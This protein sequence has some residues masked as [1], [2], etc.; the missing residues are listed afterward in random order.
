M[1]II[2][3][4]VT[5]KEFCPLALGDLAIKNPLPTLTSFQS[6]YCS[7]LHTSF[8]T[9]RCVG[10]PIYLQV[11]ACLY[12]VKIAHS[13]SIKSSICQLAFSVVSTSLSLPAKLAGLLAVS[14][15]VSYGSQSVPVIF[16]QFKLATHST[17]LPVNGGGRI[18][19]RKRQSIVF[20][21]SRFSYINFIY[22]VIP[23]QVSEYFHIFNKSNTFSPVLSPRFLISVF[24]LKDD[25][26]S[27]K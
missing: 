19:Q 22:Y 20:P 6:T 3:F 18:I 14:Q 2:C 10:K 11:S 21:S 1:A 24:T 5:T 17:F 7:A 4:I 25:S 23:C 16:M 8:S 27:R 15:P 26:W 12:Y 13:L 9:I